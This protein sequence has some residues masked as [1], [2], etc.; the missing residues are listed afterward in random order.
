MQ[1]A[2]IRG[3]Q[4]PLDLWIAGQ[5]PRPRTWHVRKYA[6]KAAAKWQI[7][8]VLSG[9]NSRYQRSTSHEGCANAAAI[10]A[11][12]LLVAPALLKISRTSDPRC[13][14]FRSTAFTNGAA[15]RLRAFLTNS[16]L[17]LIAACAG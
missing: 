16:T 17:S 13:E 5:R 14:I 2:Q 1:I 3:L 4:S 15:E 11:T 8:A 12:L 7:L 6:I 10:A 9:P